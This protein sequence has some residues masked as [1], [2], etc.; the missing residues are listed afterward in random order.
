MT[1][2]PEGI[3]SVS[4]NAG[5]LVATGNKGENTHQFQM[6]YINHFHFTPEAAAQWIEALT[7]VAKEASE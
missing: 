2:R 6:G 5:E 7:P 4:I 3:I 1:T